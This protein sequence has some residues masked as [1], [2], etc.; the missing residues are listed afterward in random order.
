MFHF[1]RKNAKKFNNLAEQ[2]FSSKHASASKAVR[3]EPAGADVD[4]YNDSLKIIQN[5]VQFGINTAAQQEQQKEGKFQ[6]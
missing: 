4:L 6:P 2:H 3:I 1:F 5:I